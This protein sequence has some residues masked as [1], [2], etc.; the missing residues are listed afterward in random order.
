VL[1][2]L[3][4]FRGSQKSPRLRCETMLAFAR[5]AGAATLVSFG[6]LSRVASGTV[7]KRHSGH[8]DWLFSVVMEVVAGRRRRYCGKPGSPFRHGAGASGVRELPLSLLRLRPGQ[9][10]IAFGAKH[11]AVKAGDPLP[12]TGG[13]I[14]ISNSFLGIQATQPKSVKACDGQSPE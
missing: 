11:V 7:R 3:V 4:T 6:F 9:V 8:S 1:G 12:P 10:K 2:T 5:A 13:D 14:Q